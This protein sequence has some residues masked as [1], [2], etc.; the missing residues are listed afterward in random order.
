MN[1]IIFSARRVA[2]LGA[3]VGVMAIGFGG[4]P[5][6]Q[7]KTGKAGWQGAATFFGVHR[8]ATWLCYLQLPDQLRRTQRRV[9]SE[10]D[11][12]EWGH[13]SSA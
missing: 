3:V 4:V 11:A 2:M 7:A 8:P 10:P 13:Q 5:A 6:A 1:S 9:L 12:A